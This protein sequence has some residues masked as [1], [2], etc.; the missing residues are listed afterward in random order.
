MTRFAAIV[1]FGLA[2]ASATA[3]PVPKQKA[4]GNPD[5][6]AMQGKWKLTDVA[7][8]GK[9]LGAEFVADLD[10]TLEVQG[11]KTVTTGVKHNQRI[12]A[13]VSLDRN[14][15]PRRMTSTDSKETDL[16]GKPAQN[17]GTKKT[18]VAI[19]KI[20]GDTLTIAGPIGEGELPK[21]FAG[22]DTITMTFTRVKK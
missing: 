19:Y 10:L 17:P 7:F 16:D 20:D 12:T 9:S 14:A 21:D 13:T 11:N 18:T 15:N 3:A 8:N 2:A 22:N 6:A 5:L 1:L 4:E